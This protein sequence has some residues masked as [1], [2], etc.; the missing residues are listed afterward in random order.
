VHWSV[1]LTF[2]NWCVENDLVTSNPCP[3]WKGKIEPTEVVPL[4][5][6][7]IDTLIAAV[8]LVPGW[9]GERRLKARAIL[10]LMRWSGM[11]IGDVVCL[12]VTRLIGQH[13]YNKRHKTKK[14]FSVPIPLWVAELVRTLPNSDPKYFFWHR[15]KD[16]TEVRRASIVSIYG[17]WVK[18]AFDAA[19]LRGSHSHQLRHSFVTYHRAKGVSYERIAEWLGHDTSETKKTYDHI[20]PERQELSD[21]TMRDSWAKMGLDAVGNPIFAEEKHSTV[22]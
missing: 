1:L 16:G 21:Q 18:E 19:G 14:Q 5:Q 13:V 22:N 9:P 4:T 7:Q 15:R 8:D 12:E 6:E 10:L 20:I 2:F 17:S 11:S 3:S